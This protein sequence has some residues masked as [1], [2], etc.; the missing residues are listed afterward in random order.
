MELT[1]FFG[2][3]ASSEREGSILTAKQLLS[4]PFK[5]PI[6]LFFVSSSMAYSF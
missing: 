3:P 2:L 6:N 1:S 5:T 4:Y